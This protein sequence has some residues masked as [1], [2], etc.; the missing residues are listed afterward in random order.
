MSKKGLNMENYKDQLKEMLAFFIDCQKKYTTEL[1]KLPQ[2]GMRYIDDGKRKQH[3]WVNHE[4]RRLGINKRPDL[5]NQLA[6]K[7][8]LRRTIKELDVNIQAIQ[9]A[10]DHY[11]DISPQAIINSMTRA[12]KRLPGELFFRP[13]EMLFTTADEDLKSRLERHRAWAEEP[14]EKNDYPFGEYSQYTSRGLHVRSNRELVISELLYKYEVPFRYDQIIHVGRNRLSPDFSFEM[15]DGD[16]LYM[17]Y[18]GMMDNQKYVAQFFNKRRL[19][20]QAGIF[21]WDN[22]I[23][24]FSNGPQ[25]NVAEI[26]AIIRTRILPRL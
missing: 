12:Y 21:E 2:G 22:M 16:E 4:K 3:I 24:A 26:D 6:R 14:Y 23:Y 17:E 1:Q 18:C 8:F 20:E 15:A 9:Y 25:V 7:E 19:Y 13:D 11:R 10:I 5:I